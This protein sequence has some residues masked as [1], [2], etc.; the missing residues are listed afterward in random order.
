MLHRLTNNSAK[1]VWL[2]Q[3]EST[4]SGSIG[5]CHAY[6]LATGDGDNSV[7]SMPKIGPRPA[8]LVQCVPHPRLI[9]DMPMYDNLLA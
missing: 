3:V 6:I 7:F 1:N 2:Y 4:S 5:A 9:I 8:K